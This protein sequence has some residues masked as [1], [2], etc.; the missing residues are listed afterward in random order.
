V[1]EAETESAE[2]P[3]TQ[4]TDEVL[5]SETLKKERATWHPR[6]GSFRKISHLLRERELI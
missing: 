6:G 1:P 5:G 4:S 3:N 2:S